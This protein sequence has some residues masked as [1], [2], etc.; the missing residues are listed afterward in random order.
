MG[1]AV[2]LAV[3][4]AGLAGLLAMAFPAF[5]R[6]GHGGVGR[7]GGLRAP[8]RAHRGAIGRG[9]S[10]AKA[11]GGHAARGSTKVV[12]SKPGVTRFVPNPRTIFSLMTLYGAFANALVHAM[13][14]REPTAAIVALVPALLVEWIVVLPVWNLLFRFEGRPSAP[15]DELVLAAAT[16]TTPFRNGKGLVSVA[17]EGRMVQLHARLVPGQAR[18]IVKV[19]DALVV[20]CGSCRR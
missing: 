7:A 20:G 9:G 5:A 13:H 18:A 17:R 16:A 12:A 8:S 14:L 15:L 6:H 1:G 4:I 10:L 3:M 19:G 11:A 2:F